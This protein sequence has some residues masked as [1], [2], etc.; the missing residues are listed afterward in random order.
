MFNRILIKNITKSTSSW[1]VCI[2]K[3]FDIIT[4]T[5]IKF[6]K[7]IDNHS[8]EYLINYL[9]KIC[10]INQEYSFEVIPV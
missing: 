1:Y 10:P 6:A 3:S 4:T 9:K 5:D 7:I 2:D 8:I